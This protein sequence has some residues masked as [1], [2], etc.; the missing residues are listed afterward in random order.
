MNKPITLILMTAMLFA[1][2]QAQA[3][4]GLSFTATNA[5]WKAEC[6]ACHVAYPANLLPAASWKAMM[7][8]LDKHFGSDASMDAATAA[9]I[10]LFLEN[11]ASQRRLD[12]AQKPSLRITETRWFVSKHDEVSAATWKNPRVKSAA[13]C[14]ACHTRAESGDFSERNIRIPR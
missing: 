1:A 14:A 10:L 11:N 2:S 5:K 7:A 8:G 4:G 6:G 12:P 3:S 9:E 13:N